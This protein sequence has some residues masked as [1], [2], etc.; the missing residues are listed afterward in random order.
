MQAKGLIKFFG[1]ALALLCFYQLIFTWTANSVES[2]A[3][4]Y[5]EETVDRASFNNDEGAYNKALKEAERNYLMKEES[6]PDG[7]FITN[8]FSYKEAKKKRLNLGLDLQG[9]MSVVMQVPLDGVITA[10]TNKSKDKNFKDAL[11]N[12]KTAETN[13]QEDFVTLF[14]QEFEKLVPGNNSLAPIFATQASQ[15]KINYNSTN[16]EVEAMIREESKTAVRTT[17]EILKTRIDKFGVSQPNVQLIENQNRI[18]VELPG[19]DD[20]DRVRKLLQTTANLEFWA[21]REMDNDLMRIFSNANTRLAE[22]QKLSAN[23]TSVETT[24]TASKSVND[25]TK[26]ESSSLNLDAENEEI[27]QSEEELKKENPFFSL[28][29]PEQRTGGPLVG[30]VSVTDSSALNKVLRAKGSNILPKSMKLLYSAKPIITAAEQETTE[31]AVDILG[32]YAIESRFGS[33]FKPPL[34]G[35]AITNARQDFDPMSN[36]VVVNMEM[37]VEGARSWAK[38][39]KANIGQFVGVVL[40]D[41]VYSAPRVN[42]EIKGGNTQISGQFQVQEA[43]DLANILKAGRLPATPRIVEA[44]TVGPSLGEASINAGLLSLLAG[45]GLVLIFMVV[46]YGKGGIVSVVAL[47]LNLFFIIGILA[48]LGATLTLPGMAGIV[49]T[50][51]MAVDANVIIYERIREELAAGSNIKKAIADGFSKSYSAIIDANL[52][53]LITAAILAYFGLGPVLGFA[54]IL[55]IGIFSSLFT[56]VLISR[57]IIDWRVENG[58]E[59]TFWSGFSKGAFKNLNIDFVSRRRISY[60][61]SGIFITLGIISMVTR[62]FEF[63]VDFNGG[64]TY[65][66]KFDKNVNTNEVISALS[67]PFK[68]APLVTTYGTPDQVKIT[69]SYEI[70]NNSTEIDQQVAE[71]LF[72]GVKG[73]YNT[74]PADYKTFATTNILSSQKVGPTIAD[75]ITKNSM[76]AGA[77]ALIGILLYITIRFRK[78]QY[79]VAAVV[80]VIHDSL[81]LLSVFSIFKFLPFS[82]EINQAFIAAILTVIGYSINDTVVVFDR[83]REYLYTYFDTPFLE[84]VNNAINSTLS[85]TIITSLTTLIVVLILFLFGGEVIRGFAFALLIGIMVG[86]YSSIFIATPL[87]V[88][89]YGDKDAPRE[90]PQVKSDVATSV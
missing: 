30:Y 68:A 37:N 2:K 49:L 65:V 13:S 88:D 28:F 46:Y 3:A 72:S 12:A 51:G 23:R 11:A 7:N 48:S 43:Q 5:A 15:G 85:R 34:D 45:I 8:L 64:R 16:D 66:V 14:R 50:I 22:K 9:G 75:D 26:V 57:L 59:M 44:T 54:V 52:T 25:S 29:T 83:I 47:L 81:I 55:M 61:V 74:P 67:G 87:V 82:M 19:V 21:I 4:S 35:T 56:A 84:T 31:D 40:D 73:L 1:I 39:T 38:L 24:S 76:I 27:S 90:A 32:V 41:L 53:T 60:I 36:E 79:G 62:S 69:T 42:G 71:L 89:L 86:T 78:W 6:K 63:G 20:A 80:T 18:V 70:E 17:F 58:T 77:L 33:D 10:L